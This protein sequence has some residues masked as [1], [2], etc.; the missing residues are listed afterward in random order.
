MLRRN[1]EVLALAAIGLVMLATTAARAPVFA[2]Q[3]HW[4]VTPI[5]AEVQAGRDCI[6]S[7]M[8]AHRDEVR[9]TVRQS[10][11][12]AKRAIAETLHR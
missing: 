8:Q 7:E 10:V 12:D 5:R 1:P 4:V 11:A 2:P 9:E 3:P 6:R